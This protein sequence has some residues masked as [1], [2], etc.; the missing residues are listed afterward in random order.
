MALPYWFE[1]SR[2]VPDLKSRRVGR[3]LPDHSY[4]FGCC[5]SQCVP[6]ARPMRSRSR[7]TGRR[8]WRRMCRQEAFPALLCLLACLPKKDLSKKPYTDL[9]SPKNPTARKRLKA[10][11]TH[12]LNPKAESLRPSTALQE[13]LPL[14]LA[15]AVLLRVFQYPG[16][17]RR[18]IPRLGH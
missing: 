3:R 8:G 12:N 18:R 6:G 16:P 7:M 15:G 10:K 5:S 4:R 9:N 1:Q 2:F 11:K 14:H 13:A 17:L